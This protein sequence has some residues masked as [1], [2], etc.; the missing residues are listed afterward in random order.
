[1]ER[2]KLSI[3]QFCEKTWMVANRSDRKLLIGGK[4]FMETTKELV[5]VDTKNIVFEEVDV[6][7]KIEQSYEMITP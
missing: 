4:N 5:S 7:T 3:Y 1:M 2:D 6:E